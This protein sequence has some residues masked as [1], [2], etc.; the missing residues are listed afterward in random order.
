MKVSIYCQ[1]LY[2]WRERFAYISGQDLHK[3]F[4]NIVKE[5]VERKACPSGR[6]FVYL[7]DAV[8]ELMRYYP[9]SKKLSKEVLRLQLL[10]E[11]KAVKFRPLSK[12]DYKLFLDYKL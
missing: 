5:P 8:E 9:I 12:D 6:I 7:N 1:A 10:E 11:H 4:L 3:V 2:N